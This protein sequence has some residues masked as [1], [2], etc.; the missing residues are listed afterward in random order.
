MNADEL[1][2]KWKCEEANGDINGAKGLIVKD[3]IFDFNSN[4]ITS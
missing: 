1:V 3:N 4:L 2:N